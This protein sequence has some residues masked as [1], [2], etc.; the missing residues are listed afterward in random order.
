M[1]N[2]MDFDKPLIHKT[3]SKIIG[4]DE[5][6]IVHHIDLFMINF[7]EYQQKINITGQM[8]V[9][10]SLYIYDKLEEYG[11]EAK[12]EYGAASIIDNNGRL[13]IINHTWVVSQWVRVN[14]QII[15][16]NRD[17]LHFT[18]SIKYIPYN[19]SLTYIKKNV[20]KNERPY[21][22]ELI[23]GH[24]KCM[25]DLFKDRDDLPNHLISYRKILHNRNGNKIL[26]NIIK[27]IMNDLQQK[28]EKM[29]EFERDMKS[30]G[31]TIR[32]KK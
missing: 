4:T 1:G 19:K 15:E 3:F 26:G 18:K 24:K 13:V 20:P 2:V 31:F 10:N 29:R 28:K 23:N 11:I 21:Y 25:T 5:E 6:V 32:R 17:V 30:M 27:K 16:P 22:V 8:C 14:N 9:F 7:Y 12:V